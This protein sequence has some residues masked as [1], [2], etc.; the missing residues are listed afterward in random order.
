MKL[1][2]IKDTKLE[3][4]YPPMVCC[5]DKHAIG[6]F[7]HGIAELKPNN[8]E[9]LS[10]YLVGSFCESTGKLSSKKVADYITCANKYVDSLNRFWNDM[11][12]EVNNG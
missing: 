2:A 10:L 9:H 4:F 8:Y 3:C 5:D 12:K 6:Q 7:L 11:D 1:Y